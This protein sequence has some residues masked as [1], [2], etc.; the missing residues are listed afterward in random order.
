MRKIYVWLVMIAVFLS[1]CGG[2]PQEQMQNDDGDVPFAGDSIEWGEQY[3]AGKYLIREKVIPN[4]DEPLFREL[5]SEWVISQNDLRMLDGVIW[6]VAYVVNSSNAMEKA[7]LQQLK[8]PYDEWVTVDVTE[9]VTIQVEGSFKSWFVDQVIGESDG[10]VYFTVKPWQPTE[11]YLGRYDRDGFTV[12]QELT[13]FTDEIADM[14]KLWSGGTGSVCFYGDRCGSVLMITENF[15]T[16][17]LVSLPDHIQ[18]VKGM[19]W[20][21]QRE[22]A[23]WFGI[24]DGK[25]GAWTVKEGVSLLSDFNSDTFNPDDWQGFA[26]AIDGE[27]SIYL[28]NSQEI[29]KYDGRSEMLLRFQPRDYII[30]E[31]YAMEAEEDGSLRIFANVD[32]E[33]CILWLQEGEEIQTAKEEVIL[34]L[35]I[36]DRDLQRAVTHFNRQSDK[37]H[38]TL[39]VLLDTDSLYGGVSAREEMRTKVQ[40]LLSTGEGPD[41]LDSAFVPDD[42]L[43]SYVAKGILGCVDDVPESGQQ[44]FQAAFQRGTVDGRL[45]GIPYNCNSL[46]GAV[47]S[48]SFSAGRESWTLSELME[49]V[50]A[51][52]AK[53]LQKGLRGF[54]IVRNYGLYDAGNTA[55]IDWEK[56]ESHLDEEPFVEFLKFAK[57]YADDRE[58]GGLRYGK[59]NAEMLASGELLAVTSSG[60]LLTNAN[61]LKACFDGEPS[62]LGYPRTE[63][64]GIYVYTFNLYLNASTQCE[65]GAKEFLRFL[66]SENE[67]KRL[68]TKS[69]ERDM[70]SISIPVNLG[71]LDTY[72]AT[73]LSMLSRHAGS[74][75]VFNNDGISY[76]IMELTDED[77]KTFRWMIDQAHPHDRQVM[78]IISIASEELEPYFSGAVSA[79][80]AARKLD[81]RVQLYLDERK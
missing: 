34:A 35:M 21:P 19:T 12:L 51:S 20:N 32:G 77:I 25:P 40:M 2:K 1:S 28:A 33:S 50:R 18:T 71:A 58:S 53:I 24:T 66:I 68:V 9:P 75:G 43:E 3:D 42:M 65:E 47:Y 46:D 45:Y 55:F 29:W 81:N 74:S 48:Q 37:Y 80:E 62:M 67:Q 30:T 57:E 79:E 17:E 36:E 7:F 54:F 78:G 31:L 23:C 39:S 4:P 63:G 13:E 11:V 49:A 6:R 22:T 38:V 14:R 41:I 59:E 26:A 73:N 61:Y 8:P 60:D 76:E 10:A 70:S 5:E 52:D 69:D 15:L 44:Y 16:K 56:G 72:I 64:N 27:G